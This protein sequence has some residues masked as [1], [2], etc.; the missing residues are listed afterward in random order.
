MSEWTFP[1]AINAA[2]ADAMDEDPRVVL[3]GEDVGEYGGM[4][5]CTLGLLERFGPNRVFDTPISE[6][7]FVGMALGAALSGIRPVVEL[8]FIDFALVAMD[9]LLNQIAKTRYMTDGHANVPLVIR[10]QGGGY[11]GAAAQHSQM[12]EALFLHVP[13]LKV[14]CPSS[15]N[16]AYGLLRA[17]INDPDPVVFVE[18]KQ[19]YGTKQTERRDVHEIGR[20]RVTREGAGPT[21]VSYSYSHQLCLEAAEGTN[22][23]VIDVRTL[24]PLDF[25]TIAA[26]VRKSHRV[27]VVHEGHRR[28]GFGADLAA[29]IQEEL[30]DE[31][32]APVMRVCAEDVPTPFAV[33]LESQSLPNVERIRNAIQELD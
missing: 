6:S 30:F 8:M 28:C 2:I 22:A 31:L 5:R 11:K 12:L 19:L 32:D 20:A 1:Q 24:N 15:P 4:F 23:E 13:G 7:G 17:A 21:V 10:T 29:Q 25:E 14:V 18:H 33:E 27:L 16:E 26:S 9:P 3:M